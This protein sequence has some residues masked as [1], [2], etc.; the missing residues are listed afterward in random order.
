MAPASFKPVHFLWTSARLPSG[1]LAGFR[2]IPART[3]HRTMKLN[4]AAQ[5]CRM[6]MY[7]CQ[8]SSAHPGLRGSVQ[9]DLPAPDERPD[10]ARL[11]VEERHLCLHHLL[12]ELDLMAQNH[13]CR[14]EC[15]LAAVFESLR[16][17]KATSPRHL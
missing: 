4:S 9:P 7:H 3:W 14:L 13:R 1:S 2:Y 8:S 15:R 12:E 17:K 11:H 6:R 16:F 5:R 10:P